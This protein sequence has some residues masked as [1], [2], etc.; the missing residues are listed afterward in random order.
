MLKGLAGCG[1]RSRDC[2]A[3]RSRLDLTR[4][5]HGKDAALSRVTCDIDRS[6]EEGRELA[7]NRQAESRSTEA[8][9]VPAL[10]LLKGIKDAFVQCWS[11]ADAGVRHRNRDPIRAG[12]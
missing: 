2:G 11:N 3:P 4:Q 7:Y 9:R 1:G 6:S 10:D 12:G 8:T 5:R